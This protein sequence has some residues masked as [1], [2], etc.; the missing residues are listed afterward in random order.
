MHFLVFELTNLWM[1]VSG[2]QTKKIGKGEKRRDE[3]R[4]KKGYDITKSLN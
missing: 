1:N 4:E 2:K 3:T